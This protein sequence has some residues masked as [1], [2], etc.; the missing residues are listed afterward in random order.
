MAH[1]F[2]SNRQP[3]VQPE[4]LGTLTVMERFFDDRIKAM[5]NSRQEGLYPSV[6]VGNF[7]T[8]EDE[9]YPLLHDQYGKDLYKL[10]TSLTQIEKEFQDRTSCLVTRTHSVPPDLFPQKVS[11]NIFEK[12]KKDKLVVLRHV[13]PNLHLIDLD[14]P[15]AEGDPYIGRNL[16]LE[17]DAD[18]DYAEAY[19]IW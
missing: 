14:Q 7:K 12:K 15:N 19:R 13:L 10:Q 1:G 6:P 9:R 4:S 18:Y 16:N 2:A 3:P 8:P 11:V 5:E 17:L